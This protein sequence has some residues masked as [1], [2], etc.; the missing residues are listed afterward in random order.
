[1]TST[2]GS[3]A[4][5]AGVRGRRVSLSTPAAACLAFAVYFAVAVRLTWPM[6]KDPSRLFYGGIGDPFGSLAVVREMVENGRL[7]FLPGT[8]HD[9]SAPE[10]LA[11][12]W[13]RGLAS[14]P[15]AL[16]LYVLALMFGPVAAYNIFAVLAYPLTGL[17]TFLLARKLSGSVWAAAIAGWAFAFYPY[18]VINGQGHYEFAHGWVL[19]VAVW[20]A[21]VL[22]ERPSMRNGVLAGAAT[23]FAMAWTPYFILLAGVASTTLIAGGLIS[24]FRRRAEV[25]RK[26]APYII[27]I[28]VVLA[29]LVSFYALLSKH[30]EA[31]QGLR[32]HS[33]E[34]L[35]A[36]SARPYEYLVPPAGHPLVG[37]KTG[38]WLQDHLHGSNPTESTLY[39][40]LSVLA[41]ASV[42]VVAA[43]RRSLDP[44]ARRTV[45]LI[46]SVGLLAAWA[47][48][49][50]EGVF[51]GQTLPFPSKLITHVTSTWRVYARLV[52]D[53]MLAVALL[54]AI[55]LGVVI[56]GRT[57]W[58]RALILGITA[59][60][61]VRLDMWPHPQGVNPTG[62]VPI[63]ARLAQLPPGIVAA[64][65]LTGI[66]T[67]GEMF[68]QQ[69]YDKPMLNGFEADSPAEQ[70]ARQL[71]DPGRPGTARALAALGV[72]YALVTIPAQR[73]QLR[74]GRGFRLVADDRSGAVYEVAAPGDA[75]PAAAFA[76]QGF[77]DPEVGPRG[78]F[79]WLQAA[80]GT[81]ELDGAC[82]RCSGR[83]R[84]AF[85]S[86][87]RPRTVMVRDDRGALLLRRRVAGDTQATIPV[88]FSHQAKLSVSTSP[89][90]SRVT[91]VVPGSPDHRRLAV[92]LRVLGLQLGMSG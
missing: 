51:L 56:R 59:F 64:Y 41:L 86:F 79:S 69:W 47:S 89:G 14:L 29:Y 27:A 11:V 16:L 84:V 24:T 1:V 34:E 61:V 42:A 66:D 9:L 92:S 72:R 20:R 32:T 30:A 80:S 87:G 33:V 13:I 7:P 6:P 31:G 85:E 19:V 2:V 37:S 36:F 44:T 74:F 49:P 38:P 90:P 39:L 62:S 22:I 8:L 77:G 46:A 83:L 12:P 45:F 3:V 75:T 55:G 40:G 54:A 23:V 88:R 73:E 63:Y 58:I 18:A 28:S 57:P 78:Q 35:N 43:V 52:V 15:S 4:T 17:A 81:I 70:R 10:G 48:A 5:R 21:L 91:A 82:D 68:D 53:V 50:P 67:Y 25:R 60:T 26:L 71:A 65:P 76:T